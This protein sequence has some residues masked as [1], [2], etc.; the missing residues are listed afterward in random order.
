MAV[1]LYDPVVLIRLN[2]P[3]LLVTEYYS[4]SHRHV[5]ITHPI[6]CNESDPLCSGYCHSDMAEFDHDHIADQ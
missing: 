3:G 6:E 2:N 5:Y 4:Q 1:S